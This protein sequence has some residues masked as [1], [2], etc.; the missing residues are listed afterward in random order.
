MS[1]DAELCRNW[2]GD[3]CVCETLDIE[4][5]IVCERDPHWPGK[6]EC[7][8]C[9]E[10]DDLD[11][12]DDLCAKTFEGQ[13]CILPNGHGGEFHILHDARTPDV[14]GQPNGR[15][16]VWGPCQDG[17]EDPCGCPNCVYFSTEWEVE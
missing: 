15:L 11:D 4:P 5:N 7:R 14:Y 12:R 16:L 10:P 3:G 9:D 2:A 6:P 13:G 17:G 1:C 8:N